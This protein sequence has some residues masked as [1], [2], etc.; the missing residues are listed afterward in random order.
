MKNC[1]FQFDLS[2]ITSRRREDAVHG[3]RLDVA[4]FSMEQEETADVAVTLLRDWVRT[5]VT[6]KAEAL[7]IC[8]LVGGLPLAIRLA[9]SY[10]DSHK[11]PAAEYLTWL[12]KTPLHALNFGDRQDKSIPVL[13]ERSLSQ[14]S[15]TARQILAVVGLLA[16]TFFYREAIAATLE[17]SEDEVGRQLGELVNYSLLERTEDRYKVTHALIHTYVEEQMPAPAEAAGRLAAHYTMLAEEQSQRGLAGY[18][19]LDAERAHIMRVL[20]CCEE[21]EEWQAAT[22]LAGANDGYLNIRGYPTERITALELGIRAAQKLTNRFVEGAFLGNLGSAFFF[23]GQVERAI[24]YYQQALVISREIGPRYNEGVWLANLGNAYTSLGREE[25]A[26][27]YY[28]QALVIAQEMGDRRNAGRN[29][30]SLG[31]AYTSLGREEQA[32]DYYQQALVIAQEMGDRP[33]EGAWLANLGNAFRSLGQLERAIDYHQQALVI[34]QEMGD[35]PSE[36]KDLNNLGNDYRVLRQLD[37]AIDTYEQAVVIAQ[38]VGMR[39]DEGTILNNLGNAYH[40]LGQVERAIDYYQQALV[41]A[42]EMG[43]RREEGSRLVS[44]GIAFRD[45]RQL[46]QAIDY[47]QQALVIAQEVSDWHGPSKQYL[48]RALLD[49]LLEKIQEDF[50]E[51]EDNSTS[52]H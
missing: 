38:E 2:L 21:L 10:M 18:L 40:V 4:P 35:R 52:A 30:G 47:H 41:I 25:R 20:V 19:R 8:E 37:Q 39:H 14:V 31:L 16:P 51:L 11:Q 33:S 28:Q 29:F 9:G 1:C 5:Q 7:Q 49:I 17:A 42:Q 6:T 46:D 45:L 50:D 3:H 32:I 34:A 43:D 23:L 24:D 22:N 36:G 12:E 44:L 27:D 15:E 48:Q 13:L 26:I